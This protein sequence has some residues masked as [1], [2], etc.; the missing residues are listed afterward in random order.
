MAAQQYTLKTV[1]RAF[2][3]L[4]VVMDAPAPLSLSEIAAAADTNTSNAFRFLRTLEASGHVVRDS[5][6][7]YAALRGGGGEIGLGRGMDILDRLADAPG[8]GLPAHILAE[9]LSVDVPQVERALHKLQDA[10]VVAK[11][12]GNE[13]WT[14]SAGM[15]RFLRPLLND[16]FLSRFIRPLMIELGTRYEETV[17]WFVPHGFEQVV[18]EVIPSPHPIRY[19]LETGGRQPAYLGAA[20]KAHMSTLAPKVVA[21]YLAT[22]QPVQLTRYQLDKAALTDELAMIR[23]RGFATS[24]GERVEGAA[25]VAVPVRGATGRVEGVVSVMMPRFRVSAEDIAE[26]GE[27]LKARTAALFQRDDGRR[28]AS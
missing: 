22:L 9:G 26:I 16:E 5:A 15:M 12:E 8:G 7:R 14:L 18:V 11:R 21:D 20:G 19:V 3:I 1:D 25:S 24:E 10:S 13:H 2:Q 6:K 17:S 27:T 28:Q 4:R 23:A